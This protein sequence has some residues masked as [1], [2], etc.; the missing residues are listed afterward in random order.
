MKIVSLNGSFRDKSQGDEVCQEAELK[1]PARLKLWLAVLLCYGLLGLALPYAGGAD[2]TDKDKADKG[3]K[4]VLQRARGSYYSLRG[5]GLVSFESSIT[6]NWKVTLK[7][8]IKA[9]PSGADASLKLLNGLHFAMTLDA[10]GNVKVTHKT[11]VVP[12]NQQ[13]ASGFDQ[14]YGG[15]E[16]AVSGLFTTWSV[17]MLTSPFP[18]VESDYKL[19]ETAGEYRL[20]YKDGEADVT[21]LMNKE[22]VITEITV[23]TSAFSSSIKPTLTKTQQG[24]VLSG[25]EGSYEPK[26]GPGTT[27]I[28]AQFDYQDVNGLQLPRKVNL[29]AV[30]DGTPNQMELTFADYQVKHR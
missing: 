20:S 3:R 6:P 30:Y 11:D 23:R 18:E 13:V 19:E 28:N 22:L 25:Y 10:D 7:D 29:D 1:T 8:Q 26:S 4:E 21:T 9:D 5:L 27:H 24:L 16:Q 15:M 14:I 17:F 12:P 2:Q